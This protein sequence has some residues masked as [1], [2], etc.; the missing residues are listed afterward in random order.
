V[1]HE[2]HAPARQTK[3][4]PQGVPLGTAALLSVQIGVPVAQLNVPV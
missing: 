1:V 2:T 3:S 4:V